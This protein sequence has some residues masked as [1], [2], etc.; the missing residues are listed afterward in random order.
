MRTAPTGVRGPRV[1]APR[2]AGRG[3]ARERGTGGRIPERWVRWSL[4]Q[5][6]GSH[7]GEPPAPRTEQNILV[8]F[9]KSFVPCALRLHQSTA[10]GDLLRGGSP[11]A[12]TDLVLA[13]V[14]N[15]AVSLVHDQ[16]DDEQRTSHNSR[17]HGLL[18]HPPVHEH[19]S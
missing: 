15:D 8:T 11:P 14:D 17:L 12:P 13:R 5:P 3:A 9:T 10:R 2:A 1:P 7:R 18:A 16:G 4:A 6:A 19:G